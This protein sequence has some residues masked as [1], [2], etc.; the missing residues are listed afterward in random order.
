MNE[1]GIR[2]TPEALAQIRRIA[3]A[4]IRLFAIPRAE[5]VGRIS[6]YWRGEAFVTEL[7][8][9]LLGHQL[10]DRWA[11]DIYYGGVAWWID[12]ESRQPAPYDPDDGTRRQNSQ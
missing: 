1:F 5:A 3:D 12:E 10:P 6:R 8:V 7:Q 11:K 9:G 2:A 4:M